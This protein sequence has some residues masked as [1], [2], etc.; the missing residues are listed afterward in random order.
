MLFHSFLQHQS[1]PR[2]PLNHSLNRTDLISPDEKRRFNTIVWLV[3]YELRLQ[4][5]KGSI[6]LG[7]ELETI[8]DTILYTHGRTLGWVHNMQDWYILKKSFPLPLWKIMFFLLR[9]KFVDRKSAKEWWKTCALLSN[10]SFI[11]DF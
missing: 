8:N 7:L 5:C 11:P 6:P 1:Y 3:C 9:K 10:I 2:C 4:K